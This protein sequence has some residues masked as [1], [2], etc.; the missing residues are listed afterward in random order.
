VTR[1]DDRWPDNVDLGP[2]S[3]LTGVDRGAYPHGNSVL[4]RGD[5]ETVLIDPSLSTVERGL[6]VGIDRVLLSHV[7]EDHVPGLSLL[8][9]TPVHAHEAD[10][11]SLASVD[12]FL[13]LYGD[14]AFEPVPRRHFLSFHFAPRPD[15]VPFRDGDRFD[16][17]DV[18]VE[19][20]HTPG[21]TGGH[22]VFRIPEASAVYLG[23]IDLSGFGPYYGDA[24]SSLVDFERSLE[25]CRELE[26]DH[27]ITFHHKG[28]VSG[29]EA[30]LGKL[31]AFAGVLARRDAALAAYLAQPR[32]L[33]E[34][35]AHRFV[36][37][38]HVK[39]P[40]VEAVERRTIE[41][42]LA[43]MEAQGAAHQ[44]EPGLWQAGPAAT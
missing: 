40:F 15:V 43:R 41:Q 8:P 7:H 44:L 13:G 17:G 18:T 21:H 12:A 22:C 1:A 37:R 32:R 16:F 25:R 30:F 39:L 20:V 11:P 3:V 35:V 6:P 19:V 42:H 31:E 9:Q 34:M 10:T 28:I 29:R 33:D 4:V 27:F 14:Y 5:R 23:D 36:Y 24:V 2:I 38:P 26:A